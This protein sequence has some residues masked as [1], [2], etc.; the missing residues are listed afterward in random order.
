MNKSKS[1]LRRINLTFAT[2]LAA[3]VMGTAVGDDGGAMIIQ[4]QTFLNGHT[5]PLSMINT[6]PDSSGQ[7]T[8]T[9]SGDAGGNASPQLSWGNAPPGT[10][11]FAV[12]AY[13]ITAQFTHWVIYN[14]P[15]TTSELPQNAGKVGSNKY[16]TQNGNDFFVPGYGGPCPPASLEPRLHIYTFTLY[17]LDR[18]LRPVPAFGDFVPA[19]PEGF[20]Q[21][22]I[23]ASREGHVLASATI[24]GYYAAVKPNSD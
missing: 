10:R 2:A 16:G 23:S 14:I 6:M 22:L 17:A 24:T 5:L 21:E 4:S 8:C 9:A 3:S 15:A 12:V 19:G 18:Y 11:T 13:D 20:Y 1:T 7:N